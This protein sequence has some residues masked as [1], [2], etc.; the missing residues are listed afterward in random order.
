MMWRPVHQVNVNGLNVQNQTPIAAYYK[1]LN[2]QNWN[3]ENKKKTCALYKI[4]N[5][6]QGTL[7]Q[8]H[9]PESLEMVCKMSAVVL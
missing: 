6:E 2:L 4:L 8:V 1:T 9:F 3:M 7:I 5:Q